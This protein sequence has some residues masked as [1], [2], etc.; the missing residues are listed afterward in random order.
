MKAQATYCKLGHIH[1]ICRRASF[2]LATQFFVDLVRKSL[3]THGN[4]DVAH[5][6][7]DHPNSLDMQPAQAVLNAFHP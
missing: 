4:G 2:F 5:L 1:A 3:C 7:M 6:L